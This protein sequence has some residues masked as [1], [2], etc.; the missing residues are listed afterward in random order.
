MDVQLR[1]VHKNDL[2]LL[3]RFDV[4]PGLIGPNWY[5]FRDAARHRRRFEADG[6]LGDEDGQLIVTADGEPA[7]FVGW[8]PA[9]F[10]AGRYR[11]IGVVLLP[12]WRGRRIGTRAQLLLCRYLFAHTSVH[13]IEAGTQPE[14]VAEQRALRRLGFQREGLLRGAEFRDGAWCDIVVFGLLRGELADDVA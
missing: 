14:N 3:A 9:G 11:T 8:R 13:R 1:P 5:G 6:W 10:G 7:G 2:D 12:E 4:E